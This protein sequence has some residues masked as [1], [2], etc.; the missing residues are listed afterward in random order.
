MLL[1]KLSTDQTI[2]ATILY[3]VLAGIAFAT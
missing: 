2:L 1:P 3:N